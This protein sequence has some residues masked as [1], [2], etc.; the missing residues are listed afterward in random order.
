MKQRL[1]TS[2]RPRPGLAGTLAFPLLS[3][4]TGCTSQAGGDGAQGEH[5]AAAQQAVT[6]CVSIQRGTFGTVED[7]TIAVGVTAPGWNPATLLVGQSYEALLRFDISGIPAGATINSATLGL[8]TTGSAANTFT[9]SNDWLSARVADAAW[10]ESAV[11]FASFS[12]KVGKLAGLFTPTALNTRYSVTIKPE[13][14]QGWLDGTIPNNGLVLETMVSFPSEWRQTGFVSSESPT[15]ALRP[16]LQVCYTPV[17]HCAPAPCRNGST[18][19][20]TPTSYTCACPPGFTGPNCEIDVNDCAP[21]PCQNGG[22][23]TD[24]VNS[25]TCACAPG[26][27][28]Q[29]CQID[30]DECA[31]APCVNGGVC[32]DLVNAYLCHCPAGFTGSNCQIDIDDCAGNPCL[33]GGACVDGVNSYACACAPGFAG[34]N[35][36]IDADDCLGNACQNGS[37]C[38][39]G[40]ASYTC[41]CPPGYGGALCEVNIDAC[42][43]SPC[44]NGGACLDVPAG[45]ACACAAGYAGANCEVDIDDCA[46][47]PCQNGGTCVDGVNGY[48]CQCPLGASGAS[49]QNVAT[50]CATLPQPIGWWKG[51][52][53]VS[54]VLGAHPGAENGSSYA[55]GAVGQAFSFDGTNDAQIPD[56]PALHL[57]SAYTLEAWVHLNN[58][59]AA[60]GTI[61]GKPR[62]DGASGYRLDV[63]ASGVLGVGMN[64][65]TYNWSTASA[66]AS[67]TV[68]LHTWVHVAGVRSGNTVALYVNGALAAFADSPPLGVVGTGPQPL[69][70]GSE[71]TVIDGR[72]L[73][74][75]VDEAAV[76]GVALTGGDIQKIYAAGPY[77]KC[78]G[79][80]APPPSCPCQNGGQC[81]DAASTCRCPSGRTGAQCELYD[82][83]N[84][85]CP[86]ADQCNVA[87]ACDPVTGCAAPVPAADGTPCDDGASC[88]PVD[89]C[90]AGVCVGHGNPALQFDGAPDNSASYVEVPDAASLSWGSSLGV[91]IHFKWDGGM[92]YRVLVS[93]PAA[94]AP[95]QS[96]TGWEVA[97]SDGFFCLTLNTTAGIRAAC[98]DAPAPV[99]AW[100]SVYAGYNGA[101]AI[102]RA[103]FATLTVAFGGSAG[104]V[105]GTTS[106]VIGRQFVSSTDPVLASHAFGGAIDGITLY[107]T[108]GNT[109]QFI[110][111]RN[112]CQHNA[113]MANWDFSEGSGA[114]TTDNRAGL[115]GYLMN[116]TLWTESAY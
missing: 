65:G 57:G 44:Q 52:G 43:G 105:N 110:G 38:I 40:A 41:S 53:D 29:N 113:G 116:N 99:N 115:V 98:T 81:V 77:G 96:D 86:G 5:L 104:L 58:Y 70:L 114:T 112:Q 6:S 35:C 49:C 75:L 111:W 79:A 37:I 4:L 90:D 94:D 82:C 11:T 47:N 59:P 66:P 23:C 91:G 76:Y 20:N 36:E 87:G 63:D 64:D 101:Q 89:T 27:A 42:A 2:C 80:Y 3:I 68:P 55:G 18:C 72:H 73:D 13:R 45:Y 71:N 106:L 16:S 26:F 46:G 69:S 56:D 8:S 48:T 107:P 17:D 62:A 61:V 95:D 100:A 7:A 25:Y 14:V 31:A 9:A 102:F 10:S 78:A 30:V 92:G 39:D 22:A 108:A 83:A 85:T 93:K 21:A 67:F 19:S 51:E 24:G 74:G 60:L 15:V 33:N 28:G 103:S 84:I 109:F 12:Q 34:T 50:G 88:S 54:D 1:R 32:A 97:L